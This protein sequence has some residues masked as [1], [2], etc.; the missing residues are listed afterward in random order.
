MVMPSDVNDDKV[1]LDLSGQLERVNPDLLADEL[2]SA[3]GFA[4]GVS[5]V[6]DGGKLVGCWVSAPEGVD[7]FDT[8]SEGIIHKVAQQHN[9]DAL[10]QRQADEEQAIQWAQT[11][12]DTLREFIKDPYSPA[13]DERAVLAELIETLQRKGVI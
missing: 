7:H 3:L 4:V 1:H 12:L 9:P 10:S 6:Y 8:Q 5:A 13:F 2:T 11:A